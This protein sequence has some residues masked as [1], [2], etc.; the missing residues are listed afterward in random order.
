MRPGATAL[1]VA[2]AGALAFVIS[3]G[4]FLYAYFFTF[5]VTTAAPPAPAIATNLVLFSVF[6]LHHSVMARSGAKSWLTR[7]VPPYLE[8][9][10]Y[11]WLASLLF[12]AVCAW[13][14]PVDGIVYAWPAQIAWVG[15]VIQ[16]AGIVLTIRGSSAIDMLDL[17]GVRPV[18]DARGGASPKHVPLMTTGLYGFVRHPLYFAWVLLVF[19][20]PEM[21]GTRLTFAIISTVYLAIAIPFEERSLVT[22]F[23]P[24]YR[25]YQETVRWRMIP[26]LY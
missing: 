24:A 17:A 16:A 7:R 12:I 13:W 19:G 8:R 4:F 6:A 20:A 23:G 9:S 10:L 18:L 14:R 11:T 26:F 2:W 5:A 3:L 1:G 15:H 21:T 25:K 22:L